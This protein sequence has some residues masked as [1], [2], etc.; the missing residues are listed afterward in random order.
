MLI[1]IHN[2]KQ[3]I[4]N[5][6]YLLANTRRKKSCRKIYHQAG[7][8]RKINRSSEL[9]ITAIGRGVT[10]RASIRY[11]LIH[12]STIV[13]RNVATKSGLSLPRSMDPR[14]YRILG[15]QK[16]TLTNEF[17][18]GSQQHEI[19]YRPFPPRRSFPA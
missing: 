11:F 12:T 13:R 15:R 18:K 19:I 14:Q 17:A 7:L 1:P 16:P 6:I 10:H 9:L 3:D 5:Y 2:S 8:C 4:F